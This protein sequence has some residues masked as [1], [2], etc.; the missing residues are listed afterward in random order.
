MP[1]LGHGVGTEPSW[2]FQPLSGVRHE[3]ES[4]GLKTS[5]INGKNVSPMTE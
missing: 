2:S 4:H 5:G 1:A 3:T